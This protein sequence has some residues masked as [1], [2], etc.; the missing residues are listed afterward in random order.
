[1]IKK[2][3]FQSRLL[4]KK[5]VASIKRFPETLLLATAAVITLI[6]MN[7]LDY[8]NTGVRENLTRIAMVLAL[9]IPLTLCVKVFF[10]R[11]EKINMKVIFGSYI[12]IAISLILYYLF[13]LNDINTISISRYIAFTISLYLTFS[14]IPYFFKRTNYDFYVVTLFNRFVTTYLYS[15]ILF[16]GLVAIIFTI[17]ILFM[18]NI[19]SRIYFDLWLIVAGIFAPA[20]F[21]ADIPEYGQNP[22]I[23]D[24]S[25][26]LRVL[27][28]YIIMPLIVA[29]SAILYAYF[30][31]I[32]I[33]AEWPDGILANLVLWFSIISTIVIFF[34]Y[35]LRN[36]SRWAKTFIS[37]F[38]ILI[39]PL[40]IM[41]FV[42]LGIRINVYGVT[43][44]RYYVLIAGLWVTGCMIYYILNKRP[45]NI[46]VT[47]SLAII[48][49]M[50]VIGPWSGYSVSKF[51]QNM[52][53]ESILKANNMISDKNIIKP[54]LDVSKADI[55]DISSILLYFQD[56]HRLSDLKYIPKNFEIGQT[57]DIFG[58]EL[59]QEYLIGSGFKYFSHTIIQKGELIN[60]K[61]YDYF[62][63]YSS[64][65][66]GETGYCTVPILVNYSEENRIV[67]IRE[68]DK[69]IYTKNIDDIVKII[70]KNNINQ[71]EVG[72]KE[73]SYVDNSASVEV[74]YV[75]SNISG[76]E[77]LNGKMTIHSPM[78]YIFVKMI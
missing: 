69:I 67:E 43:E 15:I 19:S 57:K 51:S 5:F 38:P 76:T 55:R 58:F 56:R 44:N 9:G 40:L 10:E 59:E 46:V 37:F 39:I 35:P 27:L 28:L 53:F 7:H 8:S 71:H 24:Y 31:K 63:D 29:Y 50:A 1:M 49:V 74:L 11:K 26:V 22:D 25:K 16:L 66:M 20:F 60:I 70:H 23:K 54:S 72:F 30:I 32:L 3:V 41:M 36:T 18:A 17:N 52:R 73:M 42:S 34:I 47:I 13:M 12:G 61:D 77:D 45:K 78:F 68:N 2:I 14:F 75:F 6:Y 33:T 62:A 48:S 65:I 4:G 64:Y 21:L